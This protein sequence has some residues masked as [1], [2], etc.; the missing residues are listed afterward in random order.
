MEK[1]F[2]WDSIYIEKLAQF[3]ALYESVDHIAWNDEI[4]MTIILDSTGAFLQEINLSKLSAMN[5]LKFQ[6]LLQPFHQVARQ[7]VIRTVLFQLKEH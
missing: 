2:R 4:A 7:K 5:Y 3:D 1:L 6:M